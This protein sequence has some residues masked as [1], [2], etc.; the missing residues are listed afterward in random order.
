[1]LYVCKIN[2]ST[3]SVKDTDD[4]VV[5]EIQYYEL[6]KLVRDTGLPVL[7]VAHGSV[8]IPHKAAIKSGLY[9]DAAKKLASGINPAT[10]ST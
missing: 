10:V 8:H 6:L 5:Q 7:G 9:Q 3:I 2:G 4:G 1:M